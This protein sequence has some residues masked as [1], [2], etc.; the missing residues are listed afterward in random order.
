MDDILTELNHETLAAVFQGEIIVP[1]IVQSMS[2]EKIDRLGVT[3]IGDR[4]RLRELC[5]EDKE[6]N[7]R[8][9]FG[10]SILEVLGRSL[11]V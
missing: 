7:S 11:K 10:F 2:N 9:S 3:A 5:K 1:S 4:A 8:S 6:N